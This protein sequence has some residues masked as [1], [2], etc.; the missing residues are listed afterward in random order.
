MG[1]VIDILAI[2]LRSLKATAEAQPNV[3]GNPNLLTEYTSLTGSWVLD[4][5]RSS[6]MENHLQT[7]GVAQLAIEAQLKNE[8]DD[9]TRN[10]IALDYKRYLVYK[11]SKINVLAEVRALVYRS[12]LSRQGS[13]SIRS[14]ANL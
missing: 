11:K 14:R 7:L 8:V 3:N 12:Q 4:T 13:L 5:S 10:V 1:V 9:E 2:P 6:T